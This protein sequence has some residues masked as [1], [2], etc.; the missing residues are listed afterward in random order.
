MR[1][2]IAFFVR[3]GA[4][5]TFILLAGISSMMLFRSNPYQQSVF[6]TSAGAVSS[7]V[8]RAAGSVTSYFYL[9]STNDDLQQRLSDLELENLVLRRRLQRTVEAQYADTVTPD[10]ALAPYR[11]I[12]AR[13]INN[14]ITRTHNFITVDR[15]HADGIRPDMGVFD[16]NGIVGIVNVTGPHTARIISLLNSDLRLACKVKGSDAFGS[17]VWDGRSPRHALLEEVPRHVEFAI[18][19]T[20]ITSG[21]SVVFPEG[22]PVGTVVEQLRDADDNFY[23]LKIKLMA[24]FATLSTVRIIENFQKDEIQQ[25]ETDK[26]NTSGKF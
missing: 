4:W 3:H 9:R 6:M 19:D 16:Q 20:I 17:L 8:Y 15:G 21:F 7:A 2:L 13:V 12:T 26:V 22:I 24:D 10:Q 14:S 5:F 23:T 25:V 1:Q 11:F 18:G